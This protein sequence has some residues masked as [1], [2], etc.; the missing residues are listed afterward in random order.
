MN[1]RV[2]V[3]GSN[4]FSGSNFIDHLLN[5][6]FEV[7][8]ISRSE[9]PNAVFLPYKNNANSMNFHFK[10]LDINLNIKK[11]LSEI[12]D[13]TPVYVFN[14]AAQGM[15]AESWL[16][17]DQWFQTNVMSNL[18]LHEGL[19][20]FSFLKKYIHISTPEVYGSCEGTIKESVNYYPSTP[21]AVSRAATDMSLMTFHKAYDF[22]VIFTRAAN[23]FGPGQQLYRIIPKTILMF[24]LGKKL[25]LHGG[26]R[27]V[28]SF[29]HISDVAHGTLLAAQKSKPG[30]IFHLSTD[31][32]ISVRNLVELIAHKM[33]VSFEDHVEIVGERLG[34]DSAYLLDN[35]KAKELLGWNYNVSLEEGIDQTISWIRKNIN[36][37]KKQPFDYIHKP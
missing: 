15:V 32:N 24:T 26:G 25:S 3:I 12:S 22:P 31:Q 23:V 14:F 4:S 7:L 18:R 29:I 9:E 34:K 13:F 21:Y 28:R 1:K 30:E 37:I 5:E 11:V 20:K 35:S 19:R 10:Q 17:P 16:N 36:V 8:G 33:N 6:G 27:S 2:V